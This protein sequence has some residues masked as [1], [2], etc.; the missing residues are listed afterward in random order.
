[1]EE[2]VE[3]RVTR[4]RGQE[5]RDGRGTLYLVA[6]E[7][8]AR[9]TRLRT[10]DLAGLTSQPAHPVSGE[11]SVSLASQNAFILYREMHHQVLPWP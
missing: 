6:Q 7:L 2:G 1:M 10:I 9:A 11:D 3:T 8:V 5:R 4:R